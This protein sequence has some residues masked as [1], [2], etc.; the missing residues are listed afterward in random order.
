[1]IFLK[2]MR[3]G[4]HQADEHWNHFKGNVEE[5]SERQDGAHMGFSECIDTILN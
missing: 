3:E 1:M 5:T 2:S 4:H